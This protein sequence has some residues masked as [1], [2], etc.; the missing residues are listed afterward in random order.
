LKVVVAV[1]GL[2]LDVPEGDAVVAVP[3]H[4]DV[5]GVRLGDRGVGQGDGQGLVPRD[6]AGGRV[7]LAVMGRGGRRG[8]GRGGP[9]R[10]AGGSAGGQG[11][12]RQN[13]GCKGGGQVFHGRASFLAAAF[14]VTEGRAV[15]QRYFCRGR[16]RFFLAFFA[17]GCYNEKPDERGF[18][19][20][21]RTVQSAGRHH[22]RPAP[23]GGA[24][25]GG[26]A[27]FPHRGP[28]PVRPE[29]PGAGRGLR[30]AAGAGAHLLRLSRLCPPVRAERDH[31]ERAA[32]L[33]GRARGDGGPL[34]RPAGQ[35]PCGRA[36]PA[37]G[38]PG[39][40]AAAGAPA[41][42]GRNA[43]RLDQGAAGGRPAGLGVGTVPGAAVL[44]GGRRLCPA[45]GPAL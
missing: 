28:G 22:L 1:F 44:G 37:D 34:R 16:G 6:L 24:G 17:P 38:G 19:D 33:P 27:V 43:R 30:Q 12:G 36:A 26:P 15:R 45:G 11:A 18:F 35:P 7:L 5:I 39:G 4:L 10:P 20:A 29:L 8:G 2:E 42:R 21:I 25:P 23:D 14:I 40:A 9:G 31:R 32:G 41:R 13:G 3:L